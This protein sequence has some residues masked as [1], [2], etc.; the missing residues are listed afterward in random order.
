MKPFQTPDLQVF[1]VS[2]SHTVHAFD[3]YTRSGSVYGISKSVRQ[4]A[5]L[6][7]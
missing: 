3:Q 4:L 7:I 5:N 1:T 6:D 2:F